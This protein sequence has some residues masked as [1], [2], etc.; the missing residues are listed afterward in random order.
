MQ[1]VPCSVLGTDYA[2]SIDRRCRLDDL[3]QGEKFNDD[4]G[5]S[6]WVGADKC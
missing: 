6:V 5:F 2:F 4:D 3:V 1:A